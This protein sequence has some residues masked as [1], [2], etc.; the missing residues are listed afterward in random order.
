[1]MQPWKRWATPLGIAVAVAI[2][3]WTLAV[4]TNRGTQAPRPPD[5]PAPGPALYRVDPDTVAAVSRLEAEEADA[6]S[7]FWRQEQVAQHLGR[8]IESWWDA[9]NASPH[10]MALAAQLP[11]NRIRMPFWGSTISLP[12]DIQL[13]TPSA[14][15]PVF[16]TSA[17]SNRIH[18][19]EA[20]G[21]QIENL[22][23]RQI[24]YNPGPDG[25]PGH[26]R[27]RLS[28][29]LIRASPIQR[30]MVDGD[31]DVHWVPED[32][33][34]E[35]ARVEHI[36]A[37]RLQLLLR[38]GPPPF[39]RWLER[40]LDPPRNAIAA[41]PL[42]VRDLD[43]DGLPEIV[44]P[45]VRELLKLGPG[46]TFVPQRMLAP[47]QGLP[48]TGL[49][50]D[51]DGDGAVDLVSVQ[52]EGVVLM[53]G[54]TN[55]LFNGAGHLV[56]HPPKPFEHAMTFTAGDIDR[57]GD[58]DLFLG[59][60]K[61]PYV[62][63]SMPTPCDDAQDGHSGYLLL[64][65]GRGSLSD[66]SE[67]SGLGSKLRRRTYSGSFCDLDADGRLDLALVSDFAGADLFRNRGNGRFEDRTSDWL[68]DPQGLG[69]GHAV[70]DFNAD[71][72]LDL[73]MIGMNSPTV[74]RLEHLGL[75]RPHPQLT[76]EG[77][78]ALTRGNRLWLSRGSDPGF[79]TSPLGDGLAAS[80]WSWGCTAA[81]VDND[82]WPD[83]AIVNGMESRAS[84]RDIEPEFWLHDIYVADSE[85]NPAAHLYFRSRLER[86]QGRG[87]SYGGYEKNRLYLNRS[88]REFLEVGHL[89][90]VALE[91]D[92]RNIV[93]ADFDVDGRVDLAVVSFD[94]WPSP[95]QTLRVF[96]N[97]LP[98][99]GR[100]IGFH[101]QG[102]EDAI[103]GATV[104][105]ETRDGKACRTVVSGDSHRS[106]HPVT[107]H[108]GLGRS[109]AMPIRTEVRWADGRV[110]QIAGPSAG[111]YHVLGTPPAGSD[112]RGKKE[113][114]GTTRGER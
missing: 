3:V 66:A 30:A 59:Q 82:G 63:G 25:R 46:G 49:L 97:E 15:G 83:V 29:R 114:P 60:Y 93:G 109:G 94:R 70:C 90:G 88:G 71:G 38:S 52:H 16:D 41:D 107:V 73:L 40:P 105:L 91:E 98:E 42:L 43:G 47:Q 23:A 58:V 45:G 113:H 22:E 103:M 28:V 53:G 67:G 31:V 44:L 76:R 111:Q 72:H 81:D 77:R 13:L 74:D 35:P 36:D 89:L 8:T 37:S 65:D 102:R 39:T 57:D 108:F 19:L 9:I 86:T 54:S 34:S 78:R 27:F 5:P 11:L 18:S 75:W 106:Q 20:Q 55:G 104:L 61:A 6:E 84:V 69:M 51:L 56:W 95:R 79:H 1:M 99:T 10:R 17:W 48:Y 2:G 85:D 92:T 101:L 68:P 33:N 21:W 80:G 62:H 32:R 64:N 96:R 110:S 50:T 24:A 14:S 87:Q 7:R 100:W 12:H 112:S 26:S 4:R